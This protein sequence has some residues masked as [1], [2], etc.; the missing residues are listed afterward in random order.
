MLNN[1]ILQPGLNGGEKEFKRKKVDYYFLIFYYIFLLTFRKQIN[2]RSEKLVESEF[3]LSLD[4]VWSY[5]PIVQPWA[6][7]PQR[8][9]I[10]A[11][12][13]PPQIKAPKQGQMKVVYEAKENSDGNN[14]LN[15]K[16]AK[17]E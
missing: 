5:A 13:N 2:L 9:I 16:Q 12:L 1:M 3:N 15:S 7:P 6:W 11:T 17:L 8:L 10:C 14:N 4:Q